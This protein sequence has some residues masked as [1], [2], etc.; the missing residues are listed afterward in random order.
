[1]GSGISLSKTQLD[2]ILEKQRIQEKFDE[3]VRYG[4]VYVDGYIVEDFSVE[5]EY[6]RDI[7]RINRQIHN[8]K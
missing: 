2:Y 6:W 1:M 5:A 7:K 4:N 8:I 3:Y